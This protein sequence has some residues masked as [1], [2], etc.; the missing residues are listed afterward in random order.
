MKTGFILSLFLCIPI[1]SFAIPDDTSNI[2]IEDMVEHIQLIPDKSKTGLKEIKHSIQYTF[3]ANYK[4][5]SA[6]A[7]AYYDDNIKIDKASGGS[8]SYKPFIVDEFYSDSKICLVKAS[9]PKKNATAKVA[10]RLTCIKPEFMCKINIHEE[11]D[12]ERAV[13]KFEI[14]DCLTDRYRLVPLNMPDGQYSIDEA[15]EKGRLIITYTLNN[16][17]KQKYSE[18]IPPINMTAPQIHIL[19]HFT[20]ATAL[21]RYL[22]KYIPTDDP[23]EQI[24]AQ[25][26]LEITSECQNDNEKIN[27]I[28]EFIHQNIQYLAV[29]HGEFGHRPDLAS[30]VL[31][32]RF[33]DC[34]G[35]ALLTRNMLRAVGIDARLVWIGTRETG[36]D[37]TEMPNISSGNHMIA[38]V[39]LPSDSI[40]FLD[41]TARFSSPERIPFSISG[42]QALIEDTPDSCIIK[43]VPPSLP[44]HNIREEQLT[45][46]LDENNISMQGTVTLSGESYRLIRVA[47]NDIPQALRQDFYGHI[48]SNNTPGVIPSNIKYDMGPDSLIISGS[49]T[50][51]GAVKDAGATIYIDTKI[52]SRLNDIKF[53][54]IGRTTGGRLGFPAT[55]K[56][57]VTIPIPDGLTPGRLYPDFSID[58]NWISGNVTDSTDSEKRSITRTMTLIIKEPYVMFNNIKEYDT[59]LTRFIKACSSL[60]ALNKL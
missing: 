10:F 36:S 18:D 17:K 43:R 4:A 22:Y 49:A 12:I 23:G 6:L 8:V 1:L 38:A 56:C 32:K 45:M 44:Q 39:V 40:I 35:S 7:S 16:L 5:G 29:E 9:L 11:Y 14:P 42:R 52:A 51:P 20:D 27:A 15:H 21:Y 58:N 37:W 47:D 34:K 2:V 41:G 31:R 59:E 24:V 30:E 53:D 55:I 28:N 60:I 46:T 19:G 57:K 33:G 50:I 26:A 54:L 13:L 48:F 25:K 3:R